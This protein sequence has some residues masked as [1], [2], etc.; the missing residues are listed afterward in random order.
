MS[1]RMCDFDSAVH[2]FFYVIYLLKNRCRTFSF[3]YFEIKH[4]GADP[5]NLIIAATQ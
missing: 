4:I 1:L 2:K 3:K 5:G